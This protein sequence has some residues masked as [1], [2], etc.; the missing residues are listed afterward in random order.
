MRNKYKLIKKIYSFVFFQFEMTLY[1][2]P[3][4]FHMTDVDLIV[5]RIDEYFNKYLPK[6]FL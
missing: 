2:K 6:N 1:D 3:H 4:H 5:D